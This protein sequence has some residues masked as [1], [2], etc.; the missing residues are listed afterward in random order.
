MRFKIEVELKANEQ[1]T[2]EAAAVD[3]QLVQLKWSSPGDFVSFNRPSNPLKE[4]EKY[5]ISSN[6]VFSVILVASLNRPT[7][8]L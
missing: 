2:V 3:A 1:W 8:S 7:R 4:R 6:F 5:R